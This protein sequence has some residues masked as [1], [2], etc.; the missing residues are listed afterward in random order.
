MTGASGGNEG[1]DKAFEVKKS[2]KRRKLMQ[3]ITKNEIIEQFACVIIS[4]KIQ[5]G[6]C[7]S[8]RI[9]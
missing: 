5:Y 8:N 4:I 2:K 3:A 1:E 6:I 7:R 9:R